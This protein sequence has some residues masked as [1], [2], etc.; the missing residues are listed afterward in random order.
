[1][2]GGPVQERLAIVDRAGGL[3]GLALGTDVDI[4]V[5]IKGEVVPRQYAVVT[6]P[7]VPDRDMRIDPSL[8][9]PAKHPARCRR[10]HPRRHDGGLRAQAVL[11]PLDHGL[12]GFDL[13]GNACRRRLDIDDDGVRHVD[14]IVEAVAEHDLVA[15]PRGPGGG[16]ITRRQG[17]RLA[18]RVDRRIL[19]FKRIHIFLDR[20]PRQLFFRPIDVPPPRPGRSGWLDNAGID[21]EALA[22]NK[23]RFHAPAHHAL[24]HGAQNIAVAEPSHGD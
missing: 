22:A 11:R 13:L 1:M 9:E 4:G 12:G 14:Q 10:P 18:D 6:R 2:L 20:A 23:P 3:E 7:L 8:P 15:A 21:G 16:R 19:A 24:E 5:L 17:L